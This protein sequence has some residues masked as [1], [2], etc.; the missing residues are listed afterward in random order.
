[1]TIHTAELPWED[2]G[3][4]LDDLLEESVKHAAGQF[5]LEDLLSESME[6]KSATDAEKEL[7]KRVSRGNMPK[8]ELAASAALLKRWENERIWI[9][10]GAVA[11]FTRQRCRGCG[12]FHQTFEGYF[13]QR[14]HRNNFTTKQLTATKTVD[15]ALTKF[16]KYNDSDVPICHD[17]ADFSEWPLEE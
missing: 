11:V 8:D 15:N 4:S 9:L 5:S 13:E 1:M 16:V 14:S 7:R 3:E 17:C 6:L 10:D 12:T 2:E